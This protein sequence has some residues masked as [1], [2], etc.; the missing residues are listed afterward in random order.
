MTEEKLQIAISQYI[1]LQYPDVIFTSESSGLR[2]TINQAVTLKKCRSGSALPDLWIMEARKGYHACLLEL[3]KEGTAVF[4]KNGE[5]R[6]TKH[7][8]EQEKVHHRL[9]NK[10]YFCAFVVGF[11]NAKAIVDYYLG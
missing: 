9:K 3:K 4:K 2:L 6:K 1:K 7:L 10:G 5:L 8:A 11:D